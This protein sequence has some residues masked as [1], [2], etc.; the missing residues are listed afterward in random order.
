MKRSLVLGILAL[1]IAEPFAQLAHISSRTAQHKHLMIV[2]EK[3]LPG[4]TIYDADTDEPIC[5]MNIGDYEP[6][7]SSVFSRWPHSLRA[8]LRLDERRRPRNKRARDRFF[9]HIG[10]QENRDYRHW[11]I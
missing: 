4:A 1:A 5:D 3:A 10:L 7:R 9:P 6:A 8:G 11:E 2:V